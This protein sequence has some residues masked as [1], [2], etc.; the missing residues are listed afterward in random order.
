MA[1]ARLK[2]EDR[3]AQITD[4]A[5]RV[6]ATRGIAAL[7]TS[8][9]ARA[10]GVTS[11]ALFR[12]FPSLEAVLEAVA[13]RVAELLSSTYPPAELAPLDRLAT[14]FD[15][16]SALARAH[17]G[18]PRLVLSE[19]FAHALPAR[20]RRV[21]RDAVRQSLSFVR[22]A[23]ADGQREGTVRDDVPPGVLS[24]I[25]MGTLQMTVLKGPLRAGEEVGAE[26][27]RDGL[28]ALLAPSPSKGASPRRRR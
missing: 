2:T 28:L 19:Q 21:L 10:V 14:F 7:S 24:P 5:L 15:A 3:R 1:T 22:Q 27:I 23:L 18:I 16:R 9:V 6:I 13:D 25:V 4:A 12:H 26:E 11:G 8:E 17:P 20:A